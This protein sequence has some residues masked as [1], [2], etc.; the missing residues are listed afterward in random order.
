MFSITNCSVALCTGNHFVTTKVATGKSSMPAGY[1]RPTESSKRWYDT[2]FVAND[3][4][5]HWFPHVVCS[6]LCT[7][8]QAWPPCCGCVSVRRRTRFPIACPGVWQ[9][10]SH[11]PQLPH[12]LTTQW[13]GHDFTVHVSISVKSLGSQ[14]W[15]PPQ[16]PEQSEL[17]ESKHGN[18]AFGVRMRERTPLPH[19]VVHVVHCPHEFGS[20]LSGR[21]AQTVAPALPCVH[22]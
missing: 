10:R 7:L 18:C 22:Q 4:V 3:P 17:G 2:C 20:Q 12:S 19:V 11:A 16:G 9:E 21:G 8:G 1:A 13:M 15:P 14:V 5:Q 6:V